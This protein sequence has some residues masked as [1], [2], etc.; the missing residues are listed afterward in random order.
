MPHWAPGQGV[1]D[2]CWAQVG[3][4][5]VTGRSGA[6]APG[7]LK[8]ASAQTAV[9]TPRG[10][11]REQGAQGARLDVWAR[12]VE[13]LRVVVLAE[14]SREQNRVARIGEPVL[15]AGDAESKPGEN[16][17]VGEER[18]HLDGLAACLDQ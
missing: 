7:R 2:P 14:A 1:I 16:V 4:G 8:L 17:D 6:R 18:L 3:T 9:R 13:G 11:S 15:H 10:H 12:R 5:Q